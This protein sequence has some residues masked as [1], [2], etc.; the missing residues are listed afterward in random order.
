M[1]NKKGLN[2]NLFTLGL[3]TGQ[4]RESGLVFLKK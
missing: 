2:P 1:I 3:K 4:G